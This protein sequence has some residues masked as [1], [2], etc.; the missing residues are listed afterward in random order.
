MSHEQTIIDFKGLGQRYLFKEPIT[1]LVAEHLSEVASVLDKCQSYQQEGYYVV[2]YVSYEAASA[3]DEGL[4]VHQKR[5]GGEYLAYFTVHDKVEKADFPSQSSLPTLPRDWKKR[6]DQAT[7]EA[8]IARI[9]QEIRQGN[10]Y[11]VNYTVQLD[12]ELD[13]DLLQVYNHLV[14]AQDAGHN[15]Y[16]AHDNFAVLSVSPELFFE[17]DGNLLRTR[18]MKG[19]INRGQYLEEDYYNKNWLAQDP[20]NRA[21]N[22]MI[23]DLLRNDMGKVCQIGSVQVEQ[24]CHVEA[25]STVWQMTS[26]ITGYLKDE[27]D[28]L[29]S[30]FRA[31][32]PC[33]SITGAPKQS[34]MEIINDLEPEPRGVYCGTIGVLL[35]D[36]R[37]I[38]NVAIR[39]LQVTS[40]EAIYGVGGGITW[41]SKWRD[42]YEEVDQK[43]AVL[44][45]QIET[46]D[47]I[48]TAKI[49][50]GQMTFYHEHLSR[51]RKAAGYFAYP[52][53]ENLLKSKINQCLSDSDA[54]KVYRLRISLSK[55]GKFSLSQKLL[56]PLPSSYLTLKIAEQEDSNHSLAFRYFKTSQRSHV[57]VRNEDAIFLNKKGQV[58]ESSIANIIIEK[59]GQWLTPA[60]KLGLLNGVYRQHLLD[61]GKV[62]ESV[63]NLED[64]KNADKIYACN[65][66]RGMYQI[67]LKVDQ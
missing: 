49:E 5:L 30:L 36:G 57:T 43:S 54:S 15:A 34:T 11:Q 61:Q 26:S 20:K 17:T 50:N 19:T 16:I 66:V 8:A 40:K 35:P 44:Y 9:H 47:L 2:G 62:K 7:Y 27:A 52:F 10:T 65:A 38:F 53:D 31:L 63:L 55:S 22:M 56:T 64:L 14:L 3:F 13:M 46:F 1:E 33:G 12:Q 41:D 51:L 58:L 45:R 60:A 42:E 23:V 59:D 39:S 37:R 25:Y 29:L 28:D 48:T 24:L 32:F 6:V 67:H 18:P 21:E 4:A